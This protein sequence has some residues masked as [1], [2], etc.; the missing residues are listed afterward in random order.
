M[1]Q[2]KPMPK[3]ETTEPSVIL[4]L[5][6]GGVARKKMAF[7]GLP[8][9]GDQSPAVSA[10][11]M[12]R[13]AMKRPMSRSSK[14]PAILMR[15]DGGESHSEKGEMKKDMAQDKRMI[16][17]A[18][19][20]H[21]KQ[22]HKGEHTD[23]S[24]L[25]KGGKPRFRNGGKV[26]AEIMNNQAPSAQA[27]KMG[28]YPESKV[29]TLMND[30]SQKRPLPTKT[31]KI[32]TMKTGG[33]VSNRKVSGDYAKTKVVEAKQTQFM[34]P[35]QKTAGDGGKTTGTPKTTMVHEAK[36]KPRGM[37]AGIEVSKYADGGHVKMAGKSS[38]GF[39][40]NKKMC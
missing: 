40:Y 4:K 8:M 2:F 30:S 16:K 6:K 33:A 18:I 21:D 25:K 13:P 32:T 36:K 20:M 10:P 23:L 24:K 7:G 5:K 15:K 35:K 14:V 26:D 28:G 9:A 29:K 31:G 37:S 27:N 3:M 22:E 1:G 11:P 34:S 12:G 17:K 19:S 39:T 38:N